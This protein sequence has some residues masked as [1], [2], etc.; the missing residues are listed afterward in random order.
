M[1][2]GK[3]FYFLRT[4]FFVHPALWTFALLL[5]AAYIYI[6]FISPLLS[7]R[8]RGKAVELPVPATAHRRDDV[9]AERVGP[10]AESSA[11]PSGALS[12]SRR[13]AAGAAAEFRPSSVGARAPLSPRAS[14]V[15][16][17]G[18]LRVPSG[19][20]TP[21]WTERHP[22]RRTVDNI[23]RD[24]AAWQEEASHRATL[25]RPSTR[26]GASR[27]TSSAYSAGPAVLYARDPRG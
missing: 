26:S 10:V 19:H 6:L 22:Q 2:D 27:S 9:Q 24:R 20:R 12:A 3:P 16:D 23:R 15:L 7:R 11:A 13:V 8:H 17:R 18:Q 1:P 14:A 5:C 25:S 4:T 21:A